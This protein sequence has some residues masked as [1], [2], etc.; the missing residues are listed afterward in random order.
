MNWRDNPKR[1]LAVRLIE[2]AQACDR[3]VRAGKNDNDH[4]I[5][6]AALYRGEARRISTEAG[7]LVLAIGGT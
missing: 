1:V 5:S 4:L 7:S 3:S 2:M 6:L